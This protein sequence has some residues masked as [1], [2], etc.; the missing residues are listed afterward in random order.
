MKDTA[1]PIEEVEKLTLS[2]DEPPKRRRG[3]PKGSTNKVKRESSAKELAD[4]LTNTFS[5]T[6]AVVS[7]IDRYDGAVILTQAEAAGKAL[8]D[9]ASQNRAIYN[10]LSKLMAT[11]AWAAVAAAI[12]PM[13]LAIAANHSMAP[14]MF[15]MQIDGVEP[16]LHARAR[17]SDSNGNGDANDTSPFISP[18]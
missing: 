2:E 8:A 18:L 10:V 1:E 11:S 13:G 14:E 6:G 7:M 4:A 5:M 12:M 3:R 15:L 9:A 16:T 17:E